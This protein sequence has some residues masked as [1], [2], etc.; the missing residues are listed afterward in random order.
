MRSSRPSMPTDSRTSAGSTSSGEP[1][2][3]MWVI[4]AGSSISDSTPPSDSASVKRRVPSAIAIAR[5]AAV[6]PDGPPA[7]GRN[8]TIPPNPG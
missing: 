7:A 6:R 1:A 3:D 8:E 4:A 5:S 2:T